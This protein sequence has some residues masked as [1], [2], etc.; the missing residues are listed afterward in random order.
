MSL[1]WKWKRRGLIF[2]VLVF[3]IFV[4]LLA[5]WL[6]VSP[7]GRY[8]N[9]GIGSGGNAFFEFKGGSVSLMIPL[10]IKA[11]DGLQTNYVGTYKK[12]GSEWMLSTKGGVRLRLKANLW[13]IRWIGPR[14]DQEEKYPRMFFK[15]E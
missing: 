13:S 8:Y 3:F 6:P 5:Y 7:D 14:E 4:V 12:E 11:S 1:D 2:G 15:P 9:K 10:E